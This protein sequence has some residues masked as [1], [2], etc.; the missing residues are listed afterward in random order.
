MTPEERTRMQEIC[1]KL[2][3]EKDP[4]TYDKLVKELDN[5]LELQYERISAPVKSS[6][7]I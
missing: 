5:L 4:A 1:G 3:T 7:A 6:N 2:A